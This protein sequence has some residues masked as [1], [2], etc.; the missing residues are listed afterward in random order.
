MKVTFTMSEPETKKHSTRFNFE[1]LEST[2]PGLSPGEMAK[3]LK[4][5]SF[6]IPKPIGASAKRIR[7]TIEEL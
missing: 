7:V 6:Y 2:E 3:A 4:S 5:A 1:A